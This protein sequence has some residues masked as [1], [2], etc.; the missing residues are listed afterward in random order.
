VVL[1]VEQNPEQKKQT[2]EPLKK[3]YH[4]YHDQNH[5][6]NPTFIG[7]IIAKPMTKH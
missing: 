5:K 2:V 3:I 4:I 6:T 7:K 1:V